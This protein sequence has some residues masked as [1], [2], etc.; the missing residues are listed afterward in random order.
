M[1]SI[2]KEEKIKYLLNHRF[3]STIRIW[4][5]EDYL[6]IAKAPAANDYLLE[7]K[8]KPENEVHTLYSEAI[9]V[10]DNE[11]FFHKPDSSADKEYWGNGHSCCIRNKVNVR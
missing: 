2:L 6:D 3:G 5:D 4:I 7:L 10:S 8:G 9:I 11:K 1:E